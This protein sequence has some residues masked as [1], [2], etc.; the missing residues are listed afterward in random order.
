MA[1]ENVTSSAATSPL[2]ALPSTATDRERIEAAMLDAVVTPDPYLTEIASHLIVAGGKR[3]RPILAVVAAQIGGAA[4][5]HDVVRGGVSCELVHLGSLY[6]DDVM[7][8]ADTRRGVE[9]VNAKWGNLQAILAGDFLLSRASEIAASLGTE[10]AALLA[11]TIGWLCEGQIEELRHTY[12]PGRTEDSYYAS[13]HGKTA[14]L[15]GTAARIGGIV[16][17]HDASTVDAL[18]VYGNAYGM[19]FQIV[20]DVLDVVATDAQLGK[21]A[22]H[23][24]VEGVYTLPVLRTLALGGIAGEE[25]R[26]LLGRPLDPAQQDQALSLVRSSDG[27]DSALLTARE[28]ADRAAAACAGFPDSPAT[29][30]LATAPAALLANLSVPT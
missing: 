15:Y 5:S 9:T 23:D 27:I 8:E 1:L 11:R 13:I 30:A 10:V 3:L 21:P 24:L 25:L 29:T 12:D 17:G 7:D 28:Y 22:G 16:A 18:T 4:A 14:S 20:D 6:H 19:V 26:D 2:L